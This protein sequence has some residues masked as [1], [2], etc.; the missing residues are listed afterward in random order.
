[1][2]KKQLTPDQYVDS[3]LSDQSITQPLKQQIYW[4][5]LLA[6][7][8][9][10]AEHWDDL[11][12]QRNSGIHVDPYAPKN[13]SIE[14]ANAII[15]QADSARLRR[16]FG[17][18]LKEGFDLDGKTILD[19]GCDSGLF[20]CFVAKTFPAATV[21][22]LDTCP[23]AIKIANV[24]KEQLGLTNVSFFFG[25]L[26]QYTKENPSTRFDI[27]TSIVV[28]HELL[29][30]GLIS[31]SNTV[32][33]NESQGLSLD[34]TNKKNLIKNRIPVLQSIAQLLNDQ[35]L[36]VSLDRWGSP[37]TLL[38]WIRLCEVSGLSISTASSN[39]LNFKSGPDLDPELMPVTVFQ[40][41]TTIVS[42]RPSDILSL[43]SYPEFAKLECCHAIENNHVAE[44]FY[45]ALNRQPLYVE[46]A[47]YHNG[48]GTLMT[49]VGVAGGI[50]YVYRTTTRGYRRLYLVPSIA[51]SEKA[52]EIVATRR[53]SESFADVTYTIHNEELIQSLG[54]NF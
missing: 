53:S 34:S 27:V 22:G 19:F 25:S 35:G 5:K 48:S 2:A 8:G 24:R 39:M 29:A 13:S 30:G 31:K 50:G 12:D 6:R 32:I 3:F 21:I 54:I 43:Y 49:Y 47:E 16:F 4:R 42:V 20:A 40:K 15:S 44:L 28:F 41:A 11:I 1:M 37:N 7:F 45:E 38:Q 14:F 51:L 9:A 33:D 52:E 46:E 36:L 18:F 17:W 23:E 26:E 10:F